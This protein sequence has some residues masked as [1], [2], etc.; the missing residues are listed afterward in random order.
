MSKKCVKCGETKPRTDFH[1]HN[2]SKDGLKTYCKA[3]V[4]ESS[5]VRWIRKKEESDSTCKSCGVKTSPGRSWCPVHKHRDGH[6]QWKGERHLD[7]NG[8]VYL[9]GHHDHPNSNKN[10][11]ISEHR[12]VMTQVLGRPLLPKEEVHHK[13]GIRDD[14]RPENLELWTKSQPAGQRVVDLVAWAKEILDKYPE[15]LEE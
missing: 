10:G 15:F 1:K 6:P 12:L 11:S 13:N 9:S 3:C 8:Y 14:N 4:A 5:R 7:P 2:K